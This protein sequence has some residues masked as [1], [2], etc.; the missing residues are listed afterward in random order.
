MGVLTNLINS[1]TAKVQGIIT[2]KANIRTSIIN[3]E[4]EVPASAK[5]SEMS[6]YIDQILIDGIDTSDAT[7]TADKILL[8]ETAYVN[9]LKVTGTMP[10]N[11]TVSQTLDEDTTSYTISEGYYSGG[12]VSVSTEEKTVS[13]TAAAQNV[14]PTKGKLLKKVS[15]EAAPLE[16]LTV[17]PSTTLQTKYPAEGNYG[18][19][20][21]VV[22]P[23]KLQEKSVTPS[24]N[25]Q[26]I[27]PDSGYQGLNKV[28]VAPFKFLANPSVSDSNFWIVYNINRTRLLWYTNKS[29]AQ[30]KAQLEEGLGEVSILLLLP[31]RYTPKI[32]SSG[33]TH[34][35]AWLVA[36]VIEHN[37][38]YYVYRYRDEQLDDSGTLKA[39][40]TPKIGEITIELATNHISTATSGKYAYVLTLDDDIT[41][42]GF[43]ETSDSYKEPYTVLIYNTL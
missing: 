30:T 4:V 32:E 12:S 10:N 36:S 42:S 35:I 23:M 26:N 43:Y 11:G 9:S 40:L 37:G 15:V 21:V 25:Q 3:K 29:G 16:N 22:N 34:R 7:A 8:G 28:T 14:T 33:G 2:V 20:Q 13:P 41:D 1:I 31:T 38:H 6:G 17:N 5:L 24:T 39:G 19:G 27:T 18:F